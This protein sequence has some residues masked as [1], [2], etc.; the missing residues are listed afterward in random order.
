M[1]PM[2]SL[3]AEERRISRR[4][5]L[6]DIPAGLSKYADF[7]TLPHDIDTVE[8]SSVKGGWPFYSTPQWRRF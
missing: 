1:V 8:P 2:L 5:E 4:S 6:G 7:A 3:F